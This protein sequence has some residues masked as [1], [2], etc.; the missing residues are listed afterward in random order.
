MVPLSSEVLLAPPCRW[1]CPVAGS[2]GPTHQPVLHRACSPGGR[3]P[4]NQPG[5][6]PA[7]PGPGRVR[8]AS[9]S[10]SKAFS[11]LGPLW[12]RPGRAEGS[13]CL[14]QLLYP[15]RVV[16]RQGL[17]RGA[18]RRPSVPVASY[19]APVTVSKR[20][21]VFG[22]RVFMPCIC[23]KLRLEEWKT[24]DLRGGTSR[25]PGGQVTGQNSLPWV[26]RTSMITGAQ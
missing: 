26:P 6:V 12:A 21:P 16:R 23:R 2:R 9:R 20:S 11:S 10:L 19:R 22:R 7:R 17:P 4:L 13:T 25:L 15:L 24:E 5:V 14:Q 3:G 1:S 8:P 18:E